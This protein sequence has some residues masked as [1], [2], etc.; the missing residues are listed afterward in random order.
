V[1]VRFNPDSQRPAPDIQKCNQLV[2][3]FQHIASPVPADGFHLLNQS[4]NH[5]RIERGNSN[6]IGSDGGSQGHGA[7]Q[8]WDWADQLPQALPGV[9][10]ETRR[11]QRFKFRAI[12][13]D[14]G[15]D[16]MRS[17]PTGLQGQVFHQLQ[18]TFGGGSPVRRNQQHPRLLIPQAVSELT[19]CP[20]IVISPNQGG[21]AQAEHEVSCQRIL[22]GTVAVD[23]PDFGI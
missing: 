10:D 20:V 9:D 22:Q 12:F 4:G 8:G 6:Q 7:R 11:A 16:I 3:P 5:I 13:A 14:L 21:W 18:P 15:D 17:P 19:E 23:Q 2:M 1:K